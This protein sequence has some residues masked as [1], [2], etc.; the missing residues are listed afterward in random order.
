MGASA[1]GR[2]RVVAYAPAVGA[3]V[4]DAERAHLVQQKVSTASFGRLSVHSPVSPALFQSVA[5]L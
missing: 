1:A 5:S 2:R 4:A 3:G